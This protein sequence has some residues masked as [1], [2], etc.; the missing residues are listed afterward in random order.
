MS[1]GSILVVDDESEIREGLE[2]LLVGEGYGVSSADTGESGLGKLEEKPFDLLLL[3]V[4][5]PD[6]NGIVARNS[7]T[8]SASADRT[9]YSVWI[10]R[11]GARGVQERRDGLHHEAVVERR[12]TGTSGASSGIAATAGRKRPAEAR[13]EAAVQLSEHHRQ[14]R[15]D[16]DVAGLRGPSGAIAFDD[17]HQRRKRDRQGID[18]ESNSFGVDAR[19]QGVCAG[20]YGI[21]SGG[22]AGVAAVW[23]C[24]RRVHERGRFEEGTF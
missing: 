11:N 12:I 6:R 4:S 19:R 16:A 10:H 15:K 7:R 3:D 18:C 1:K 14:K 21:D 5:L 23:A 13:A 8:R 9:D 2:L 20:E 22:F 17:T 24:E